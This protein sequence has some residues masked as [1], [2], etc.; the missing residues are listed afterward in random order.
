[1]FQA[2]STQQTQCLPIVS[3]ML[4]VILLR[5]VET[6]TSSAATTMCDAATVTVL[7]GVGLFRLLLVVLTGLAV[8]VVMTGGGE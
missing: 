8:C 5:V 7:V 2:E 6:V 3:A 4:C 1:M